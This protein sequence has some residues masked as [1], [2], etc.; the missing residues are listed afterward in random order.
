MPV[1]SELE[2]AAGE[3]RVLQLGDVHRRHA[4][5]GTWP[6]RRSMAVERG[7][8]VERLGR[9]DHGRAVDHGAQRAQHAAEAMIKRHRDANPIVCR[10]L[11]ALADVI[12][13][14]QQVAM[15]ERGGLGK[16]G[17]AGSVLDVDR[18]VRRR[19]CGRWSSNRLGG[20]RR[21][22]SI[23]TSAR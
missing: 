14:H 17:R 13:V 22:R 5:D 15:A 23:S 1:R 21:P 11:L 10:Q 2:I 19:A 8:G 4:V 16:A 6:A 20:T 7:R 12:G 18:L 3:R 9:N